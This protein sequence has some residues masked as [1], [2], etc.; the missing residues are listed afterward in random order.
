MEIHL[1]RLHG[2][3]PQSQR[4]DR[5]I[6]ARA[7]QLHGRGMTQHVGRHFLPLQGWALPFRSSLVAADQAL[8]SIPT[9]R[10]TTTAGEHR[11]RRLGRTL[12]EALGQDFDRLLAE[13]RAAFLPALALAADV[14]SDTKDDMVTPQAN[15]F[16]HP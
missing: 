14:R 9:Q 13:R 7:E 6:D 11:S 4:D 12:A 5:A 2:L 1:R 16:G 3:V 15:E 10:P 8:D